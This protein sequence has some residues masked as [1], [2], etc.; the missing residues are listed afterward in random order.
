MD[1]LWLLCLFAALLLLPCFLSFSLLCAWSSFLL[2]SVLL[3][4]PCALPVPPCVFGFV[5]LSL[6]FSPLLLVFFVVSFSPQLLLSQLR[7]SSACGFLVFLVVGL[8]LAAG[9][10]PARFPLTHT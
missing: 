2:P 7:C 1:V 3:V 10:P 8:R 6:F 5:L 9:A 4:P